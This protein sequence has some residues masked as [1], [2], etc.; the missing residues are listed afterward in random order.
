MQVTSVSSA[1]QAA[2]IGAAKVVTPTAGNALDSAQF[3]Q[4][5]MAQLTHQNPLE[6]MNNNE[7]MSQFSQLNSLQE[8]RD[9]HTAMDKVS[10]SNQVNY[11]ASLIGKTVKATRADG[12]VLEGVVDGVLTEKDNPQVLIGSET[13]NLTDVTEIM[14]AKV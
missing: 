3:M 9:I 1:T 2:A 7:M 8:L 12:K 5:L 10:A 13:V 4:I 6:P 11:Y 14:G